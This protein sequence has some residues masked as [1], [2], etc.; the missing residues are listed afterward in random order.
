MK[1]LWQIKIRTNALIFWAL[2]FLSFISVILSYKYMTKAQ[3]CSELIQLNKQRYISTLQSKPS[4]K[5]FKLHKGMPEPY[6]ADLNSDVLDSAIFRIGEREINFEAFT[7]M[8]PKERLSIR[9]E[10]QEELRR[11]E[12]ELKV[13]GRTCPKVDFKVMKSEID[14]LYEKSLIK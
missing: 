3:A 4:R 14:A 12:L 2:V 13:W 5:L 9:K 6:Q 10:D 7:K 8:S 1:D 11:R